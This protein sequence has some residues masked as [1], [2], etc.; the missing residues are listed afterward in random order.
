MAV[1]ETHAFR[2]TSDVVVYFCTAGPK[3][4]VFIPA[5]FCTIETIKKEDFGG[6]KFS[7]LSPKDLPVLTGISRYLTSISKASQALEEAVTNISL[8][9]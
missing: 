5:G 4:A 1:T 7:A 8:H 9:A 2:V 6:I 3:D